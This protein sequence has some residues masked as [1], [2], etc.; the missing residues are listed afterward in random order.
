MKQFCFENTLKLTEQQ[1]LDVWALVPVTRLSVLIRRVAM[2]AVAIVFLFTP[3]TLALGLVL[4]VLIVFS[5][6]NPRIIPAG[7]RSLFHQHR[8]LR[9]SLTYGVS[10]EKLWVK[11]SRLETNVSWSMLITWRERAGWLVLSPSGIP[12]IYLALARLKEEGLYEQVH[13][14]ARQNAEEF[15]TSRLFGAI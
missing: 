13:E 11:G 1:Y 14:L 6:F 5:I 2:I 4:L 7:A 8:Y 15:R 9:D 12:P 3:Y 10:E